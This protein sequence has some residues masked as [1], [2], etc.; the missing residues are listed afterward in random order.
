MPDLH[1]CNSLTMGDIQNFSESFCDHQYGAWCL[2][3]LSDTTVPYPQRRERILLSHSNF[4][5]VIM[6]YG[7]ILLLQSPRTR[8]RIRFGSPQHHETLKN[9]EKDSMW[10]RKSLG[11]SRGKL[12]DAGARE[13]LSMTQM[14]VDYLNLM[15]ALQEE[16]QTSAEVQLGLLFEYN[17]FAVFSNS[18]VVMIPKIL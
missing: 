17:P 7:W 10:M 13:I 3:Y 18:D 12:D 14:N 4:K 5:D 9:C 2:L 6:K 16:N 8:K 11:D 15:W 1:A